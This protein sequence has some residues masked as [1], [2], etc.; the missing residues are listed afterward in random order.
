MT[1]LVLGGNEAEHIELRFN[2]PQVADR[3]GWLETY[4]DIVVKGFRGSIRAFV[5]I[6][7]LVRF[8]EQLARLHETLGGNAELATTERQIMLTVQG[9]GRGRV[10][11]KG[12]A[13]SEPCFGNKLEFELNL[14]QT[15]L[16]EPLR[17]LRAISEQAAAMGRRFNE[18]VQR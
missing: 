8:G 12:A 13:Y 17:V 16:V 4:V 7:D 3:D 11:V 5:E 10:S 6:A 1:R 2:S 14:D 18:Q 9:D 15:F